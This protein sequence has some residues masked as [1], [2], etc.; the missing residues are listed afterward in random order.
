MAE[1]KNEKNGGLLGAKR[2]S[3]GFYT[4]SEIAVLLGLSP[5]VIHKSYC[6]GFPRPQSKWR[7]SIRSY[8]TRNDFES[9]KALWMPGTKGGK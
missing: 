5:H 8:Y 2:R 3:E 9:I 4:I 1:T 7:G 6:K